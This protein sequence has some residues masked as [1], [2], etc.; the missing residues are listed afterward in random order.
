MYTAQQRKKIYD[1]TKGYCHLCGKR[2]ALKNYGKSGTRG[3]WN[4]DHSKAQAN[5][6]TNHLNNLFPACIACNSSKGKKSNRSVRIENGL[7]EIPGQKKNSSGGW[8]VLAV[9][10]G[11][12]V[13]NALVERQ[14]ERM[15]YG[16]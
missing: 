1:R 8:V 13:L 16:W 7:T 12:I 10:T 6:G 2:L 4:V 5:D 14:K 11:I 3:A 9:L 15:H